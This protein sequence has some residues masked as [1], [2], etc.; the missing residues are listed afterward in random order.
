MDEVRATEKIMRDANGLN[1]RQLALLSDALRHDDRQYTLAGHANIHGVT[2]ETARNDLAGL[3]ER[4]FLVR[5]RT[6]RPFIYSAP[7][8]LTKRLKALS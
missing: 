1:H 3:A 4:G 5:T 7:R 6:R 8:D 2:H